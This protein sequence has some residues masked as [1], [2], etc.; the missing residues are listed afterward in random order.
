[1]SKG[2]SWVGTCRVLLFLTLSLFALREVIVGFPSSGHLV[3]ESSQFNALSRTVAAKVTNTHAWKP[4]AWRPEWSGRLEADR[5]GFASELW[6]QLQSQPDTTTFETTRLLLQTAVSVSSTLNI[7]QVG[8]CDGAWEKTNDPM[9]SL[10]QSQLVRAVAIE[11]VPPLWEQLKKRL[12]T[13]PAADERLLALNAAVCLES[14]KD[15]PFYTVRKAF[16]RDHPEVEH[17]AQNE[18]GSFQKR[19]LT[20]HHIPRQYIEEIPVQCVSPTALFEMPN[21]PVGQDAAAVDVLIV[22]AEGLDADLVDRF[23]ETDS[24]RPA[25]LI[26]EWKHIARPRVEAVLETMRKASYV[27]WRDNDQ[28]V[29][30]LAG[31]PQAEPKNML[32]SDW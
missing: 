17:W 26:F 25:V 11:P 32:T 5:H 8:A 6:K 1:M 14:K 16:S 3:E 31:Q 12:A 20:K 19:H 27:Y 23:L 28:I 13:L 18:L 21:S 9:Q 4:V 10:F 24:F 15:V 7:V 30:L 2:Q 29:G 22:D